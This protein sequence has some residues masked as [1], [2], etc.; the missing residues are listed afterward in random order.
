MEMT[1][2]QLRRRIKSER[3]WSRLYFWLGIAGVVAFVVLLTTGSNIPGMGIPHLIFGLSFIWW[4]SW[5]C[6]KKATKFED[7]LNHL[8]PK[9]NKPPSLN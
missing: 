8:N 9:I 1:D 2:D 6:S 7:R 5:Y 3:F 4:Y